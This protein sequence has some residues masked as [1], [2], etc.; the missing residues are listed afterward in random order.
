MKILHNVAELKLSDCWVAAGFVRNMVWDHLH[1]RN[2]SSLNDI[3]V[4]YYDGLDT[5]SELGNKA[6][7]YLK[8]IAPDENWQVRNQAFMHRRNGHDPYSSSSD[9]M[10][11]WPEVETAVG[12]RLEP[13]GEI[14]ICAPLGV[15]SLMAGHLTTNP[16]N[17]LSVF[18][19]RVQKKGG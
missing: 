4:I 18:H 9:A 14:A 13:N 7:V 11:F 16:K 6:E 10:S 15:K 12:V 19:E 5:T 1:N 17:I 8:R 3:D 2:P